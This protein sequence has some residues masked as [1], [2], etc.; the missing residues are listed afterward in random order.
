M[1]CMRGHFSV[2]IDEIYE[3]PPNSNINPG[4]R[5]DRA[6]INSVIRMVD[7][8]LPPDITPDRIVKRKARHVK[9]PKAKR[10]KRRVIREHPQY[11]ALNLAVERKAKLRAEAQKK[12]EPRNLSE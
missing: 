10:A 11:V 5:I 6:F 3:I 2:R 7:T 9:K 8:V 1:G 12:A 4:F